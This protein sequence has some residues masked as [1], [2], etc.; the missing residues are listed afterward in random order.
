M[1]NEITHELFSKLEERFNRD[2]YK[3]D[4]HP[5]NVLFNYHNDIVEACRIYYTLIDKKTKLEA[6]LSEIDKIIS[7]VDEQ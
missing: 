6:A 3:H 7:L 4:Q 5:V 2:G 1:K